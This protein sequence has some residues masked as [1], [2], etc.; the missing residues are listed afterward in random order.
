MEGTA[1]G[2]ARALERPLRAVGTGFIVLDVIRRLDGGAGS[3]DERRRAGGTCGNV[4]A[5]LAFLGHRAEAVGRAGADVFGRELADDLGRWGVGTAHIE[6]EP[7]RP[8]PVVLEEIYRDARGNPRHRFP[9][10]C[11]ACGARLPGYRPLTVARAAAAAEALG[12]HD[13]LF[14]DRASPGA[15]DLARRGR[16]AGALVVFEPTGVGDPGAFARALA[17]AHVVKYPDARRGAL[18]EAVGR[19]AP[20]AQVET[21]GARGLRVRVRGGRWRE[22][23]AA[24]A[25]DLRDASGSGDWCTAGLLHHLA[26]A[27]LRGGGACEDE[28]AVL[29]ALRAG[30]ALAALNCGYHGAR[31]AMYALSR[32]EALAVAAGGEPPPTR[33]PPP[34]PPRPAPAGLCPSG[35]HALPAGPAPPE[36][37]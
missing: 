9:Q 4:L 12:A 31:G 8:T 7:G 13:V 5:I 28:G 19:A 35:L 21:R 34:E 15:V 14:F 11:G 24:T 29:A 23:G 25:R 20:V 18:G 36:R 16:E 30:Q 6:A 37:R 17:A 10:R 2:A 22:L 26:S 3:L 27:G 1:P 32:A 33:E